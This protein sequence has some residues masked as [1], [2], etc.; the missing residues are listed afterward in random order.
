MPNLESVLEQFD[1]SK[2]A[3][4]REIRQGFFDADGGLALSE[5]ELRAW[6]ADRAVDELKVVAQLA[7]IVADC[8]HLIPAPI[9]G[10]LA[11]QMA[12]EAH[13]YEILRALVP[14]DQRGT[15]DAK[16]AGLAD[17]LAAD[18]HW[19]RL[20][21]AAAAGNPYAALLDINIVH[22][23]YS[24][25]AI[26]ELAGVPFEDV[27]AAYAQIGADEERHHETG[28]DLLA[29]LLDASQGATFGVEEHDVLDEAHER[30]VG[31]AMNWSW[32]AAT[33]QEVVAGAHER[34]QGGAMNWSW[35]AAN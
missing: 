23:G 20:Q 10:Q 19:S 9:L 3:V 24:A 17:T 31:G 28:R 5:P 11:A 4:R 25:A 6:L 32:P 30:A 22:E 8:A 1:A 13:H 18:S 14:A 7:H 15:L 34:A 27:R 16:V 21:A 26:E 35:P 29:W 2:E 33:A 12:D